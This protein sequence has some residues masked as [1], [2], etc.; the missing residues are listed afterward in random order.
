M[1]KKYLKKDRGTEARPE[2]ESNSQSPGGY[3]PQRSNKHLRSNL[4]TSSMLKN[5]DFITVTR[6][7]RAKY[8]N[9]GS[10]NR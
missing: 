9:G 10:P 2:T 7:S 1:G 3:S 5:A 8:G 4:N 6:N